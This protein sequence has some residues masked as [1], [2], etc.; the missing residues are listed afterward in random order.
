MVLVDF[1]HNMSQRSFISVQCMGSVMKERGNVMKFKQAPVCAQGCAQHG[2]HPLN[3][4]HNPLKYYSL[5]RDEEI[6][7]KGGWV[8]CQALHKQ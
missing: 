4:C 7:A 8:T 6:E 3:P 5:F 1:Q 2:L